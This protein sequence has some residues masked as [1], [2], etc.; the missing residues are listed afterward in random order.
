[1][2]IIRGFTAI[3]MAALS[4]ALRFAT[5]NSVDAAE[6]AEQKAVAAAQVVSKDGPPVPRFGKQRAPKLKG[7]NRRTW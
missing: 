7:K 5:D 4:E 3:S 2:K 6:T 1:V